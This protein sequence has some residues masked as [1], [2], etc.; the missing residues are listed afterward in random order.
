MIHMQLQNFATLV[1]GLKMQPEPEELLLS[2]KWKTQVSFPVLN[3]ARY[4]SLRA[5][6]KE[7]LF[8]FC[9]AA[10]IGLLPEALIR[11]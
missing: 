9:K 3:F 5:A 10:I 7:V 1:N 11:S 8:I 2:D 6:G 4:F